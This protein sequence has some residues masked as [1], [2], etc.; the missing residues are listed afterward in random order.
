MMLP[1]SFPAATLLLSLA[2]STVAQFP[3]DPAGRTVLESRFGE[4][5]TITYKEVQYEF[6]LISYVGN[7]D[8]PSRTRSAKL[9]PA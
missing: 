2:K 4:G 5:V 3:A 9:D 8:D 1:T 7:T 6:T